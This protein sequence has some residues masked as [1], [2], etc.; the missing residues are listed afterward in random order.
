M[1]ELQ[2]PLGRQG[3]RIERWWLCRAQLPHPDPRPC[4]ALERNEAANQVLAAEPHDADFAVLAQ[5]FP[6]ALR[7]RVARMNVHQLETNGVDPVSLVDGGAKEVGSVLVVHE[8]WPSTAN[9][10]RCAVSWCRTSS[11]RISTRGMLGERSVDERR[12]GSR[13]AQQDKRG[14]SLLSLLRVSYCGSVGD[15][16]SCPSYHRRRVSLKGARLFFRLRG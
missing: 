2:A 7:R 13:V 16:V 8:H 10:L 4:G 14:S 9:C 6:G 15:C 12:P 1:E 11:K 3:K 5:I